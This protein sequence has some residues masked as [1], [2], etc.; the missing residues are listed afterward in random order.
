MSLAFLVQVK[1]LRILLKTVFLIQTKEF[2]FHQLFMENFVS[3]LGYELFDNN[4]VQ[5]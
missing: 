2:D 4:L 3:V 5:I 1:L